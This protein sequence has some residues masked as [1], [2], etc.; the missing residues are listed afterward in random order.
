MHII[1]KISPKIT[2]D[3]T[4]TQTKRKRTN[5]RTQK[6]PN[7]HYLQY[8]SYNDTSKKAKQRR[9]IK[10]LLMPVTRLKPKTNKNKQKKSSH[11][12]FKVIRH[13]NNKKAKNKVNNLI[14]QLL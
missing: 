8:S 10:M 5:P 12:Y 13:K 3:K 1:R 14:S 11:F 2:T 7:L 9:G 4:R 6:P